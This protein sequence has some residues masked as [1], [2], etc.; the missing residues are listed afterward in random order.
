M[1]RRVL[2]QQKA[3]TQVLSNDR[4]TRHLTPSWQDIEVLE[5]IKKSLSP[6]VEFTDALSGEQYVSVSFVKP[7]LHLFSTSILAVQED[8]TDLSKCIKQKIV[9]YLKD[10]YDNAPTQE[11]LDMASALDP[12]FK[13]KYVTEENGG[14][15]EAGLTSEMKTVME[16]ALLEPAMMLADN[17]DAA[18]AGGARKKKRGLGS[19]FKATKDT[20]PGP[21]A[22]QPDQAIAFELQS[23]LRAGHWTLRPTH[24]SGGKYHR[25]STHGSPNWLGNI[26]ASQP[27]VLLGILIL[28]TS[29][30]LPQVIVYMLTVLIL[31]LIITK[32]V[33]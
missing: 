26:F 24:W 13:L 29:V 19:F 16:R 10:K 23:Y 9:D 4:K 21:A 11:L 33:K 7:T 5:A 30:P 6:L 17:T 15:I 31:I 25:N 14:S 12:R 20:A 3:I 1:I 18:T 32:H 8:D 2:E 22:P 27:Q 28:A